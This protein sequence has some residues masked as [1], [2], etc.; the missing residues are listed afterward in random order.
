MIPMPHK[1][2]ADR[3]HHIPKMTF[4]VQNW[5][6]YEVGLCRRGS[7]PLWIEDAALACWQTTGPNG[8]ARYTDAAIQTSLMVRTAFKLPLRQTEGLM[9]SVL[10]L[11]GLTISAPDHT[12]VSRRAVTL[13]V[14]QPAQVPS[15][16]LHVLIDST[17]LQVYGAGRWLEAKHRAKSRRKWR[18]L[19]LAVD[20]ASGMIVAQTLTDQ[21]ADD[22]SQ[23]AP[24]LD[25]IDG[26]VGRVTADGAY[27]GAPTYATI[28]AHGDNIE[29]VIPP[30]STAVLSG[31]QGPLAQRDRHLEMITERGRL[32]WQKAT[33][34]GKRSLVETT[35]GRYKALIGPRL[36][37]RGFAAQQTEVAIGVAVLNQRL[38]ALTPSVTR[39]SSH[40]GSGGGHCVLSPHV[41]VWTAPRHRVP[42]LG[43]HHQPSPE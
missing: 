28:A 27:D 8:Q 18:K 9:T 21:D 13:P 32:A 38:D 15:G 33:D 24:L 43:C 2:N 26:L 41:L 39:A 16:P 29:V 37:A 19:H 25:Q 30:R 4:K 5:P 35:M 12:T 17:G 34:Y 10:R 3:R 40:S 7:L 14:I 20:A 11:M 6:A 1:H 36:R 23:V 22:P 31:E 42:G